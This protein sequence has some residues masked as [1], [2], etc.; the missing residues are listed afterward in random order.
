MVNW[1]RVTAKK[2]K[3]KVKM[4]QTRMM[5]EELYVRVDSQEREMSN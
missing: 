4:R 5:I 2:L 3:K 1:K